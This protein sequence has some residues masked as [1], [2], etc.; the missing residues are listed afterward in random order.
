MPR[1]RGDKELTVVERA[2]IFAY[3]QHQYSDRYVARLFNHDHKTVAKWFERGQTDDTFK[4]LPRSGR[5]RITNAR[6]D[7][8][9]IRRSRQDPFLV[10]NSIRRQMPNQVTQNSLIFFYNHHF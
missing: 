6:T 5:P 7:R 9:I 8:L 2:Q 1:K 10:A 4:S 3:K